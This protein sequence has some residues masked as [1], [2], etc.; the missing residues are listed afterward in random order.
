MKVEFDTEEVR[1]LL[2]FLCDRLLE[3]AALANADRA[4]ISK[5]RTVSMRPGSEGMRDLAAKVNADLQ[6]T[7]EN[8]KRAAVLKPDWR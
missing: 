3:E 1:E 6:R 7:V 5:W 4:A 2:V 8:K